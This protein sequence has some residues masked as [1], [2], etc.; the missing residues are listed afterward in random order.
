VHVSPVRLFRQ[1]RQT[2]A[3]QLCDELNGQLYQFELLV[4][5]ACIFGS[6]VACATTTAFYLI[7][8]GYVGSTYNRW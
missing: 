5:I 8:K 4:G 1:A 2:K 7:W 6:V 3:E